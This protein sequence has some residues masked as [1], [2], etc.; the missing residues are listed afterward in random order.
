M[1]TLHLY[2]LAYRQIDD[3]VTLIYTLSLGSLK[4]LELWNFNIHIHVFGTGSG[5]PFIIDYN[6]YYRKFRAFSL[7]IA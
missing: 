7:L 2:L 3:K 5:N 4:I 6:K 1:P